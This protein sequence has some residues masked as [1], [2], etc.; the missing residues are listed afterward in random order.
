[1]APEYVERKGNET[2]RRNNAPPWKVKI[3]KKINYL[4]AEISQ[5]TTFID[6]P[7]PRRSLQ[8]KIENMKRKYNITNGQLAGKRA[9]NQ[10]TVKALAAE[11]RNKEKKVKQK[12]INRQFAE[13]PR[14]VYRNLLDNSIKVQNPPTKEEIER[15][16]KPLYEDGT[17]HQESQWIEAIIEK[18]REKQQMPAI[19]FTVEILRRKIN[20]Y[21]N[22]KT[23]GL[24]KVPKFYLKKI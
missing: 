23:P 6:S 4:R 11:I 9:E 15:F 22:F 2:R 21:S 3:E 5:I 8:R 7:N 18:N 14:N 20:E 10:A 17:E 1:M 24:D 13:N 16:W 12:Q 19:E